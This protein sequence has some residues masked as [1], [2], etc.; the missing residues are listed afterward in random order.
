MLH[1]V[2]LR[3]VLTVATSCSQSSPPLGS[4]T[5]PGTAADSGSD[6]ATGAARR[7]HRGV[8][9]ISRN[10]CSRPKLIDSVPSRSHPRVPHGP[11]NSLCGDRFR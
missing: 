7:R 1:S 9:P 5:G 4:A 2:H 3:H 8:R 11:D 6:S 10:V